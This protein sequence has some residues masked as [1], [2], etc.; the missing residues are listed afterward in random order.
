MPASSSASAAL[1]QHALSSLLPGVRRRATAALGAVE[2]EA[3]AARLEMHLRD[4]VDP[5]AAV[6]GD[7]DAD[8][9]ASVVD[10]LV[11]C[12]LRAA[13]ARPE[14]LRVVDRRREVDPT[15]FQRAR[16]MGYVCYADRFAGSLTGVRKRLDYLQELGIS[17]LHLMPLLAPR[18]GDSDGG[19][20]VVDYGEVDPRLGTMAD[21][22]DL[23]ADLHSRQ[24]ALCVDL[25][26]NHTAAE[27]P[28]ARAAA[29]GD[30][31]YR[32]F[33]HIFPD[34]EMPDRYERTLPEVFPDQ[35]PG[36]FTHVEGVGWVWTTFNSFQWDL[37]WSNPAVLEAM[38]ETVL[39]LANRGIDV[40][41]LDAAPFLWK[42]E[43]TDC[44]NQPEVH[45]LLQA[46]RACLAVAAP[47]VLFK[48]EAIV[49]PQQLVQYLG[50]H[51]RFRPECDL[52]YHNQLMVMLWSTLATRDVQLARNA[53]ARMRAAPESTA[54]VTYLRCHDDIGWAVSD[55]DAW[56]T[57]L[58]PGAHRRFLSDF[59]A[60]THDGSFARGALFQHNPRTGD[61][62]IS[63][64]AAAL[65][66]LDAAR[67][68]GD[69]EEVDRSIRRLVTL[70]SVVYAYG[71]IP[72]LYMGDELGLAN[73]PDWA[74][75]PGHAGDNRWMHRPSM[76]WRAAERRHDPS[77]VEG[78]VF[79]GIVG[80]A[81]ARQRLLA[82][83]SGSRAELLDVG[84]DRVLAVRRRH[85]RSGPLVA[86]AA[87][88]DS[89][90]R[91]GRE[92][93][94]PGLSPG[95]RAVLADRD[96]VLGAYDLELPAWGHA[97]VADD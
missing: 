71:G 23:A 36:S 96:V 3:V 63:G 30:P 60:G 76:D 81:R 34:R 58:D 64:T 38:V 72:L 39:S 54:W 62:R 20:A 53:L 8:R 7:G 50:A 45:Q 12:V 89:P 41:R 66:G 75:D 51:D 94:L 56:A 1:R 21:L 52:A 83:R 55:E 59:F 46:M 17:Y 4:L 93:A 84:D 28:W 69:E 61:S 11:E 88:S 16:T 90:V 35:A 9:P 79:S 18:D 49:A 68:S 44:Q 82:L 70:Y 37:N 91:L 92:G 48:A 24:M 6:Y 40:L 14:A 95:A 5:V 15:W 65:C 78:R 97:W 33:F 10:H 85:P 87:F 19:Y 42:R 73:D 2:G 22:E 26:V 86:L 57:G 32:D 27:H 67:D 74:A 29:A 43:G 47:G 77:S 31:A 13:L 25:V 80:L